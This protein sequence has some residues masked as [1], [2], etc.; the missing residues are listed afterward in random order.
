MNLNVR[1]CEWLALWISNQCRGCVHVL[2][3]RKNSFVTQPVLNMIITLYMFGR[4]CFTFAWQVVWCTLHN[5]LVEVELHK[6]SLIEWVTTPN[7]P[8]IH[9]GERKNI[10]TA[11]SRTVSK[12]KKE[13]HAFTE[14]R[15]WP[16]PKSCIFKLKPNRTFKNPVNQISNIHSKSVPDKQSWRKNLF[17]WRFILLWKLPALPCTY[18]E[19]QVQHAN[20]YNGR[21]IHHILLNNTCLM[22]KSDYIHCC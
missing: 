18:M 14:G 13:K 7:I 15:F 9:L 22:C 5:A 4:Y 6:S 1:V 2:W 12:E 11:E 20:S 17:C 8:I 3:V 16:P 21:Y 19:R 10:L